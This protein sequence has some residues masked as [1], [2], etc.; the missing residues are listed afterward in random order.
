MQILQKC[1]LW[2]H[3]TQKLR[4]PALSSDSYFLASPAGALALEIC[5]L[6]EDNVAQAI[7]A[8]EVMKVMNVKFA[9]QAYWSKLPAS[10]RKVFRTRYI[11]DMTFRLVKINRNYWSHFGIMDVLKGKQVTSRST[12]SSLVLL[13]ELSRVMG[14]TFVHFVFTL[15]L[16]LKFLESV[17]NKYSNKD[18]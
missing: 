2:V 1:R 17:L 13:F 10:I 6:R 8:F 14:I 5:F 11:F 4:R 16:R 18:Q 3:A 15:K 7:K 9:T 12:I